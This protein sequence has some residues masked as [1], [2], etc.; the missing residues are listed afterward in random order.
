VTNSQIDNLPLVLHVRT[1][2]GFGGGP[3]KTILNS[4]RYLPPLGYRS[5]CA[6][7]HPPNDP[8]LDILR[9]RA[10]VAGAEIIPIV[11]RGPTDLHVIRRLSSLCRE[12]NVRIWHA[13]DDKTNVLGLLMGRRI[14]LKLVTTLHGWVNQ[15]MNP[16]KGWLHKACSRVSIRRYHHS[17]AVSPDIYEQLCAW[18]ISADKRVLIANA[19][20]TVHFQRRLSKVEAR[21]QLGIASSGLVLAALGRLSPE[22]GFEVLINAVS[23]VLNRGI[24]V[25]LY[26]GGTG[27]L[28]ESL[29]TTIAKLGL[30]E[31]VF[32]LGQLTDP[33]T[34]LQ[35]ADMFVLSSRKEGLPNVILEAMALE[36][37]VI[38]TSLPGVLRVI[39][40]GENGLLVDIDEPR[41]LADAICRLKSN[42]LLSKHLTHNSRCRIEQEFDFEAR[43]RKIAQVYDT[44][45][46]R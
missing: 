40:D 29:K 19:I 30:G 2:N 37:P 10:Q 17:I 39:Q 15:A 43:M 25:R 31:N 27:V 24:Q 38:A 13:H 36:T 20:D 23:L 33:R 12:R 28:Y 3:E 46:N 16:W 21:D 1:V 18:G 6:Y 11:D 4:P 35:A 22:K 32:L 8:G 42:A 5:I 9:E 34:M 44:V 7:L 14:P 45:L 41:Q 26:I